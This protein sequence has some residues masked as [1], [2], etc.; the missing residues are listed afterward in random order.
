[1][2]RL[3]IITT[4]WLQS[5]RYEII[6]SLFSCNLCSY[7]CGR[8]AHSFRNLQC[9]Y[10]GLRIYRIARGLY[11]QPKSY[12]RRLSN[13][14]WPSGPNTMSD[15]SEIR[16]KCIRYIRILQHINCRSQLNWELHYKP[17]GLMQLQCLSR[18]S[19]SAHR[20]FL[21]QCSPKA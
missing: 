2:H 3:L 10:S 18:Y 20:I 7:C 8:Q 9:I 5:M 6:C 16:Y 15:K 13:G 17:C 4:Q 12:K 1:M 19:F 21:G 14:S 11:S